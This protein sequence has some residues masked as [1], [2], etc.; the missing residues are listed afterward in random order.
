[1][2][3]SMPPLPQTLARL[4]ELDGLSP[5][6]VGPPTGERWLHL[7]RLLGDGL[8]RLFAAAATAAV[9]RR[10]D[11]VG[12][13][14]ASALADVLISTALPALLVERRLPAITPSNLSVHIHDR[15]LWFDSVAVHEPNCY[16]LVTDPA[17]GHATVTAVASVDDLHRR[18]ASLLVDAATPWFAAIRARAPF[19]RRGMWGQLADGVGGTALWAA[20]AARLDQRR[21]W[22]EAQTIVDLIAADV[23]ELRV[24]PRLFPVRWGGGE[25]LWQVKGTCCLWY[26]TFEEPDSCGDGY[27]ATCP[28]RPDDV[29][30][31]RLRTWLENEAEAPQAAAAST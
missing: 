3:A 29:R 13:S 19:G 12:A 9:P 23:P 4:R 11:Y 6:E 27:C 7:D 26:T 25:T 8:D 15:E 17:S 16:A 21:M 31:E 2:T 10:A 30:H 24:R 18:I 22:A 14:V 20:R 1:M 5:A 28:L